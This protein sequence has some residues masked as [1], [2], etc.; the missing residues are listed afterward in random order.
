MFGLPSSSESS[1]SASQGVGV[2]EPGGEV[3]GEG[4]GGPS[5]EVR[6]TFCLR[7]AQ[8]S[9]ADSWSARSTR[10]LDMNVIEFIS[11]GHPS[12]RTAHGCTEAFAS[13]SSKV[14]EPFLHLS[15]GKRFPQPPKTVT[16]ATRSDPFGWRIAIG[17]DSLDI[18][19][20]S[21][22]PGLAARKIADCTPT[23]VG[24]RK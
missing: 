20:G 14:M 22:L 24:N 19:L 7:I 12:G 1:S 18:S 6:E 21:R 10:L 16:V 4:A 5:G 17:M 23:S 11:H 2:G 8:D 13:V 15:N 3:G 9:E